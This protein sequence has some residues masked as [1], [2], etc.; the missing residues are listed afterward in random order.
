M[1]EILDRLRSLHQNI[2]DL[3]FGPRNRQ[4][5]RSVVEEW[6]T[7]NHDGN[8]FFLEQWDANT[9]T[10]VGSEPELS[11][12]VMGGKVA[13]MSTNTLMFS[14][15]NDDVH[16]LS[17]AVQGSYLLEQDPGKDDHRMLRRAS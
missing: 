10:D 17:I 15:L 2:K 4:R 1:E 3:V 5:I 12:C 13:M 8:T 6:L 7:V 14:Q 9:T 16:G 11:L